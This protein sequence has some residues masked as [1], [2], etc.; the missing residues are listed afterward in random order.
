[1]CEC[2]SVHMYDQARTQDFEKGVYILERNVAIK[3]FLAFSQFFSHDS[4]QGHS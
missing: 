2:V 3:N 1:M 4:V